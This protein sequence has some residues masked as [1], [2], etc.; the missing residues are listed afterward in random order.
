M[1][2][3]F[4][5]SLKLSF[6]MWWLSFV[7][8]LIIG[9]KVCITRDNVCNVISHVW[10]IYINCLFIIFNTHSLFVYVALRDRS[11][12]GSR[13]KLHPNEPI[14]FQRFFIIPTLTHER[15]LS[16]ELK[17][18]RKCELEKLNSLTPRLWVRHLIF[19]HAD[20][21]MSSVQKML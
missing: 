16:C 20:V 17:N 7:S 9:L 10:H 5:Q 8:L 14:Y 1:P 4:I 2:F 15:F 6:N 11:P 3:R 19:G 18:I 21:V 12:T 13:Q